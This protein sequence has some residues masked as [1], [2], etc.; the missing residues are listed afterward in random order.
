MSGN[1]SKVT[2]KKLPGEER[3][4]GSCE[5]FKDT[6]MYKN[7]GKQRQKV[8]QPGMSGVES[9]VVERKNSNGSKEMGETNTCE[10]SKVTRHC[11]DIKNCV[12]IGPKYDAGSEIVKMIVGLAI[13][14]RC[15]SKKIHK[16]IFE[17]GADFGMAKL[18]AMPGFKQ[19]HTKKDSFTVVQAQYNDSTF[20]SGL[21]TGSASD[22][23]NHRIEICTFTIVVYSRD[24]ALLQMLTC[25]SSIKKTKDGGL[26]L[27]IFHEQ[28]DESVRDI[29]VRDE[30]DP[31]SAT[32]ADRNRNIM[33]FCTITMEAVFM[34]LEPKGLYKVLQSVGSDSKYDILIIKHGAAII[35]SV[36]IDKIVAKIFT[37]IS[38]GQ[39]DKVCDNATSVVVIRDEVLQDTESLICLQTVA[40]GWR[41]AQA[42]S[43]VIDQSMIS[44]DDNEPSRRKVLQ[45]A[46]ISLSPNLL[47]HKRV[48]SAAVDVVICLNES[49]SLLTSLQSSINFERKD[50]SVKDFYAED[51]LV[52][53][54]GVGQ[55]RQFEECKNLLANE[56]NKIEIYGPRVKDD[57]A[58]K[59][60][61]K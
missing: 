11:K 34:N 1:E 19:M 28:E 10:M 8:K 53:H 30:N 55:T 40:A 60:R 41:L 54:T 4:R 7:E 21:S 23:R 20:L 18:K 16:E 31:Y 56:S 29:R 22:H 37:E 27:R 14:F 42:Q 6:G 43:N 39:D 61:K 5:M 58:E 45:I 25:M 51:G 57:V 50:R 2:E 49:E 15:E 12:L 48:H 46:K 36:H 59:G 38:Q 13:N 17:Q 32:N 26:Y 9:K 47:T 44:I 24:Y 35:K 33:S 3:D 52:N